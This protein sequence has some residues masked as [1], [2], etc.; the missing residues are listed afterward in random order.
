MSDELLKAGMPLIFAQKRDAT[1]LNPLFR[2]KRSG[3]IAARSGNPLSDR[4]EKSMQVMLRLGELRNPLG[5]GTVKKERDLILCLLKL[6]RGR[7]G[8][9]HPP[10]VSIRG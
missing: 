5:P 8:I 10:Q 9:G 1:V 4:T 2:P 3:T 6:L 7:Q